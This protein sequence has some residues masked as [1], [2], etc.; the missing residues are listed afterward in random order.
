MET[1]NV[2]LLGT[3]HV[4]I[5]GAPINFPYKKMEALFYYLCVKKNVTRPEIVQMLWPDTNETAG[6]KSLREALYQI[7]K[8]FG[9]DCLETRDRTHLSFHPDFP[10]HVDW[11]EITPENIL[12]YGDIGILSHFHVKNTYEFE[13]WTAQLQ[14]EYNRIYVQAVQQRLYQADAQKDIEQIKHYSKIL[15]KK[16][17]Y[18]EDYYYEAMDICAVNGHYNLALRFY[19]EM[20]DTFQRE[21]GISPS[22]EASALY[23]RILHVKGNLNNANQ[24]QFF[25]GRTEEIYRI[26]E[27]ITNFSQ[28]PPSPCLMFSGDAGSGKTQLLEQGMQVAAGL[29]CVP[30]MTSCSPDDKIASNNPWIPIFQQLKHLGITLPFDDSN[31]QDLSYW[32][33]RNSL[34]TALEELTSRTSVVIFVDDIHWMELS[35][36]LLLNRLLF[37][38]GMN[39]IRLICT[40]LTDYETETEEGLGPL[41]QKKWLEIV[42]LSN[43]SAQETEELLSLLV[44]DLSFDAER[45]HSIYTLTEGNIRFLLAIIKIIQNFSS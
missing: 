7:K 16:D 44:P 43:F 36:Q 26:S 31:L 30:L 27:C 22:K 35:N 15:F 23:E 1:I 19:N 28:L 13:E 11:D 34:T 18:N 4:E 9:P 42:P 29:S 38:F 2:H 25:Y 45:R 32:K 41:F 10:I 37:T 21:L 24:S 6:R 17:P 40:C 5:D 20:K 3:P 8:T 12:D 14:E 39:K 33:L